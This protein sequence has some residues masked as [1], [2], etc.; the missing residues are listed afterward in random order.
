MDSTPKTCPTAQSESTEHG[1]RGRNGG[2]V[3]HEAGPRPTRGFSGPPVG[4]VHRRLE[5]THPA[6]ALKSVAARLRFVLTC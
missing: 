5:K 3:A 1:R 6:P 4:P 2:D